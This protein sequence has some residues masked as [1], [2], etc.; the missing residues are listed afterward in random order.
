MRSETGLCGSIGLMAA[1][2]ALLCVPV[3][4]VQLENWR[5]PYYQTAHRLGL[6]SG[7]P[8]GMFWDNLYSTPPFAP[9]LWPDSAAFAAPHWTLEPA[10]TAKLGNREERDGER[11]FV[12]F[13]VL[14]DIRY[15]NLT[16]RQ[17]LDVDSR[18]SG[19]SMYVWHRDRAAAG[20]IE[21]AYAQVDWRYGMLRFGRLKRNWGPWI[22]RSLF[23]SSNPPTYDAFEWGVHSRLFEFRHLFGAFPREISNHDIDRGTF[24]GKRTGRYLSA[25]ALN[26]MLGRWATVGIFESEL[27]VRDK[28]LPDFQYMNPFSIY[29]VTNTNREGKG[30]LLLGLQWSVHPFTEKVEVLGQ[31][32]LDDIQVDDETVGDQ[33]PAHWGGDFGLRWYDGLPLPWRHALALSYRRAS[34]WLYTV[35]DPNA[36]NGER[37]TF[38]GKGLGG[39]G[40]DG[41]RTELR[42]DAAGEDFWTAAVGVSYERDGGNTIHSRWSAMPGRDTTL[43]EGAL[44]YRTETPLSRREGLVRRIGVSLEASALFRDYAALRLRLLNLWEH[45]EAGGR[46]E[47]FTYRPEA[48]LL[49]SIHYADFFFP[50]P[51]GRR[52]G[53]GF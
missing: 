25:H 26:I 22:D 8:S 27:L 36:L 24:S 17:S 45:E 52:A 37:Y 43:P 10:L 11:S 29:T 7:S 35:P 48:A 3:S 12:H 23:L 9:E 18:N 2:A 14:N 15:R 47:G 28:G 5:L 39:E 13:D 20:R 53:E 31:V 30:N 16:V 42:L 51:G 21:E 33:E 1:T 41:D 4:A 50:L 40:T 19:D 6:V 44:G 49:L 38:T 34:R 32:A 46:D